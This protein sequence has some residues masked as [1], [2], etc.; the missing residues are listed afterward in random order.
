MTKDELQ[1]IN[2]AIEPYQRFLRDTEKPEA[3]HAT[4]QQLW[5]HAEQMIVKLVSE[6]EKNPS[7]KPVK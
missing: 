3:W 5:N 2:I 1:K 6:P 7:K 4:R